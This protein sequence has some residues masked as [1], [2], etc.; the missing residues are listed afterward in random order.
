MLTINKKIIIYRKT[1]ASEFSKKNYKVLPSGVQKVGSSINAVNAMM[2]HSDML[3]EL[4]PLIIGMS[5]DEREFTKKVNSYWNSIAVNIP[6]TGKELEIGFIYNLVDSKKL[7][8]IKKIIGADGKVREFST[9][10]QLADYVENYI[11]EEDKWRYGTPIVPAD[12]LL[13]RYCLNYKAVANSP[14]EQ[15]L[16][17][18]S[19]IRFYIHNEAL[20][21]KLEKDK[22]DIR[23]KA[24]KIY[25]DIISD[26]VKIKKYLY[27]MGKGAGVEAMDD[28]DRAKLLE[29]I[30]LNT[31]IDLI[32]IHKD[33]EIDMKAFIEECITAGVL[34]RLPNTDL[35]VN[36]TDNLTIGN[37][38][39]DAI[40]FL[41][42][43]VN[44][45]LVNEITGR[46]KA[47]P[48]V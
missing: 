11:E 40:A 5:S 1:D 2:I 46:L 15:I 43:E 17:K 20:I 12:Y 42:S 47:L 21:K 39:M 33:K 32:T 29:T 37:N 14:D 18:S 48:K 23:S 25:F 16:G 45:K 3:N 7:S 38:M 22:F 6:D 30:Y 4:M 31:P 41:K 13:W 10:Q 34:R 19:D 27:A 26:S 8:N 24:G 35:I 44:A 36:S 28:I 9:E